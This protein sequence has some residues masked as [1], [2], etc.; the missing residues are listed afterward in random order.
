MN[1]SDS[2]DPNGE[3]QNQ[4]EVAPSAKRGRPTIPDKWTRVISIHSDDLSL[5][6]SYE[7]GPELLMDAALGTMSLGRGRPAIWNPIFWP[8][9]F[10]K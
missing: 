1:N 10:K 7:L 5:V 9:L 3:N 2:D 4:A 8:P 6:R